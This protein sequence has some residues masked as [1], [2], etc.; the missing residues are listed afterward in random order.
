[1]DKQLYRQHMFNKIYNRYWYAFKS[2]QP[3]KTLETLKNILVTEEMDMIKFLELK[4]FIDMLTKQISIIK[5]DIENGLVKR[6]ISK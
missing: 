6:R 5:Y 2:K 4:E 3:D 1:M